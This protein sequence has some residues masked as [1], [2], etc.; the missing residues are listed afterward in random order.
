MRTSTISSLV[1]GLTASSVHAQQYIWLNPADIMALPMSGAAWTQVLAHA[2]NNTSNPDLS[3]PTDHVDQYV[4]AKALAYVRTGE[5]RYRT[6]VIAAINAVQGTECNHTS[7][8]VRANIL[9]LFDYVVAG[10]LVGMPVADDAAWRQYLAGILVNNCGDSRDII[11]NHEVR[12][13]NWGTT[14]G[15]SRLAI[16][17]YLGDTADLQQAATVFLGW[18]D[19][20]WP[21][22]YG[23]DCWRIGVSPPQGINPVSHEWAGALPDDQR[24]GGCPSTVGCEN[25]VRGAQGGAVLQAYLVNR[26][27]L[28]DAWGHGDSAVLR[29]FQFQ[30][31][32]GCGWPG[33]DEW[34]P[35]LINWAY[36]S[37]FT[38]VTP[39][40]EG[41]MHGYTDWTHA[42]AGQPP[43]PP[44]PPLVCVADLDGDGVVGVPDLLTLLSEWGCSQ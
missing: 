25:Y 15:A 28:G 5:A 1:L 19:G 34:L 32:N 2:Q 31:D 22:S 9:N 18:L 43:P 23:N 39:A 6:E 11:E 24:R 42:T 21:H 7:S 4:Y 30:A 36:G 8:P 33:N 40:E 41:K 20:S 10:E 38:A 29:S 12:P 13:N 35:W 26:H 16:A 44:P 14:A 37:S 3:N 27:G 17:L